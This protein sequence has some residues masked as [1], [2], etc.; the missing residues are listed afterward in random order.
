LAHDAECTE[1]SEHT[2][3]QDEDD[4]LAHVD[5]HWPEKVFGSPIFRLFG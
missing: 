3:K 4:G 1:P 2:Y 5:H